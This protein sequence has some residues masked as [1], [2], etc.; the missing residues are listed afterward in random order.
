MN[1]DALA[2]QAPKL[3]AALRGCRDALH[4]IPEGRRGNHDSQI[5]RALRRADA[6]IDDWYDLQEALQ[7]ND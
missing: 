6:V 7:P 5:N 2:A 4:D 1:N 3:L